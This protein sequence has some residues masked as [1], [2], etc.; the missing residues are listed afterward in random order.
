MSPEKVVNVLVPSKT[1]EELSSTSQ[2]NNST[3]KDDRGL[4]ISLLRH[5][6]LRRQYSR[7]SIT[8]S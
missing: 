6:E 2:L 7:L 8:Q 5:A 3:E 4:T 1:V